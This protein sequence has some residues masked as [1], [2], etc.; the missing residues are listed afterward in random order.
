MSPH[1]AGM[2]DTRVEL[3]QQG[4]AS[5]VVRLNQVVRRRKSP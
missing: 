5:V 3:P 2:L 4:E 1:A